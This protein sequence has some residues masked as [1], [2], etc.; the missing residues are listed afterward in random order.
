MGGQFLNDLN[1]VIEGA[2][3]GLDP[4]IAR[5]RE[6]R[7]QQEA[8]QRQQ[9]KLLET[10]SGLTPQPQQ[11]LLRSLV[12]GGVPPLQAANLVTREQTKEQQKAKREL[13]KQTVTGLQELSDTL[14]GNDKVLFLAA[15]RLGD[16]SQARQ[17]LKGAKPKPGSLKGLLDAAKKGEVDLLDEESRLNYLKGLTSGPRAEAIN[18][19]FKGQLVQKTPGFF[20]GIFGKRKV[21]KDKVRIALPNGQTGA[22][23]I[24]N[25]PDALLEGAKL[26]E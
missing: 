6:Q 25:L 21:N 14:R 18:K 2:A 24:K 5:Q 17:I 11:P 4:R 1:E 23:P 15:V 10:L 16:F 26:V 22:I 13:E 12:Q 9:S 3:A 19:Q 20:D 7:L 8:S